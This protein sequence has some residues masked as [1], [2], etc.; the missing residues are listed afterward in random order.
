MFNRI[1]SCG[2]LA[3][4]LSCALVDAAK[5]RRGVVA[6]RQERRRAAHHGGYYYEA[7]DYYGKGTYY[8]EGDD[9]YGEDSHEDDDDYYYDDDCDYYGKGKGGKKGKGKGKGKGGKKSKKGKGYCDDVDDDYVVP[10][11]DFTIGNPRPTLSLSGEAFSPP[12]AVVVF[13][14]FAAPNSGDLGTVYTFASGTFDPQNVNSDVLTFTLEGESITAT[15]DLDGYCTRTGFP[16]NS[17]QGYCHFTYTVAA[18]EVVLGSFAAEGPLLNPDTG[19]SDASINPC[20]SLLV[21]GGTG[22][23][24]AVQGAVAFCPVVLDTTFDPPLVESLPLTLDLFDDVDGYLHN[25]ELSL[26]EEFALLI[27]GAEA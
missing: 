27:L 8:Y 3:V 23:F 6:S 15:A 14:D 17:V 26:D 19:A 25:I 9:Y 2:L 16:S 10:D 11:D 12:A 18:D 5:P 20:S 13:P 22:L 21:T 7:D 24:V 4:I 1:V